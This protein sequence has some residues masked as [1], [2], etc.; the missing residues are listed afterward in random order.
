MLTH[1]A[2]PGTPEAAC[3]IGGSE[4]GKSRFTR[5]EQQIPFPVAPLL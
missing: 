4:V 5:A 3:G 2:S 1:P